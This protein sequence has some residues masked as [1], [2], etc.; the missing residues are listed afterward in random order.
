MELSLLASILMALIGCGYAHAA[1]AG[2]VLASQ[3]GR[4]NRYSVIRSLAAI[5]C[6][7]LAV[8]FA[9]SA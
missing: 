8:H 7:G 9:R 2:Y 3:Q 6:I 5:V 1:G 4:S